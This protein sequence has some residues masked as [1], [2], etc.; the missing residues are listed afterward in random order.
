VNEKSDQRRHEPY[1]RIRKD[2][3]TAVLFVHGIYGSPVQFEQL[4]ENLFTQGYTVMAVLLPGHGK[5][6][7]DFA[8]SDSEEWYAEVKKAAAS[9]RKNHKNIYMVGHSMGGLMSI[10]EGIKNGANGVILMS[11][12]MKVKMSIRTVSMSVRMLWGNPEKDD[13]FL[14]SYRHAYSIQRSSIWQYASGLPRL[15]D[16]VKM[17]MST[18]KALKE[19]D[20][21]VLV[22]QSSRDETVSW[23][24]VSILKRG[25]TS[26]MDTLLLEKSGHSYYHPEDIGIINDKVCEFIRSGHRILSNRNNI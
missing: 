13:E 26:K 23:Q 2:A 1:I 21:P 16:V 25:L 10:K 7:K 24:S 18:R 11:V 14:K 19:V 17:T 22:I 15:I 4:A 9:L 12:P 6:A 8:R 3:D 20:F 5:G